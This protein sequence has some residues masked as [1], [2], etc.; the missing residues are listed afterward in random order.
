VTP[1]VSP[2]SSVSPSV[3]FS[4]SALPSPDMSSAYHLAPG[5][6]FGAKGMR[7]VV[8]HIGLGTLPFH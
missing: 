6:S 1:S 5:E 8:D 3:S 7:L 2:S 4:P